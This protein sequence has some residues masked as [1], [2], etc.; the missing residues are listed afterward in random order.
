MMNISTAFKNETNSAD[1]YM[2]F[3]PVKDPVAMDV[4][5]F[6]NISLGYEFSENPNAANSTYPDP[7]VKNSPSMAT[8]FSFTT[9]GSASH[10][11][12]VEHL[13]I[14]DL[15]WQSNNVLCTF[16]GFGSPSCIDQT[17]PYPDPKPLCCDESIKQTFAYWRD[18]GSH[19]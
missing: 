14:P 11:N 2:Q 13:P 19:M 12:Y 16:S 15:Y 18:G 7:D 10:A 1:P 8:H 6:S 9:S 5:F 4:P 3:V 17:P